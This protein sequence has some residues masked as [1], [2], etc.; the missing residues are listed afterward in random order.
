MSFNRVVRAFWSNSVFR[1]GL[2]CTGAGAGG[3]MPGV[4][5]GLGA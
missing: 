1:G 5:D 4:N 3:G 2:S